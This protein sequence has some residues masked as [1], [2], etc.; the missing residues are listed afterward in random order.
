MNQAEPADQD[1]LRHLG[2][3]REEPELER[4]VHVCARADHQKAVEAGGVDSWNP[5]NFELDIV[6]ENSARSDAYAICGR[7]KT[8]RRCQPADLVE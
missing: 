6:R 1:V 2:E 5:T 4:P 8:A 7:D 3:C